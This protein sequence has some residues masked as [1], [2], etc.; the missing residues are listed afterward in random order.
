[1]M[2]AD[3]VKINSQDEMVWLNKFGAKFWIGLSRQPTSW[4]WTDGSSLTTS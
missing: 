3:M 1:M 4:Q 2:G